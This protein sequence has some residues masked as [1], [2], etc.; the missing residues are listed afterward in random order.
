MTASLQVKAV[1]ANLKTMGKKVLL[2]EGQEDW[3]SFSHLVQK[4]TGAFPDYELGYCGNDE[5]VLEIL[6]GLTEA[7][8]NKQC[9]IGAVLDADQGKEE[10]VGDTGIQAR[11]RSLKGRLEKYYAIPDVFPAEGLMIS[12]AAESERARLPILGI[13][14][15][16]DNIRDGIFEDLIRSS[17]T[18][19]TEKY[20]SDVVDKATNDKMTNFRLVERS[21]AIV[22]TH[23]AWQ[24]PNKKHLGEAISSHFDNLDPACRP[25]LNW[26]E[27][28]FGKNE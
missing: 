5:G 19:A 27:R 18:P 16:P 28:L 13:W 12:P 20:V 10:I 25:F 9:V 11:L 22:K 21:K 24:D 17:I 2:V 1:K 26:L 14:L 15:M 8:N 7:S 4:I 6:S 3:H 23:I